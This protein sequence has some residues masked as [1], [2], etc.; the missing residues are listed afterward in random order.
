[1]VRFDNDPSRPILRAVSN[2]DLDNLLDGWPHEPGQVK[3]R[4]IIGR[5]G[6]EKVQLRIDLGLI[7]M[8]LNGRPDG[9]RPNGFESLLQ[10]HQARAGGLSDGASYSLSEAEVLALQQEGVQYYHRYLSLFQLRDFH[11][12]IRDTERNLEMFDF[13]GEHCEDENSKWS[14]EQFRPYVI[15]M[16]TRARASLELQEGKTQAAAKLIEA[17]KE[18]IEAF[19]RTIGQAEWIESSNELAFLSEWLK[20][21]R[22]S[23]PLTPLEIMERDLQ[24]AI[25]DEA[26]ERA[27]ELR[28]AIRSLRLSKRMPDGSADH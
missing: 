28:D 11:N 19:Y 13:V 20:E 8:E 15:M 21:V 1:S 22:E 14:L 2:L 26:Y 5:D 7:Q 12:V 17:G 6:R 16:N 9:H 24:R 27:A 10:Y 25:A 18:K 3:A 4:K 23:Q